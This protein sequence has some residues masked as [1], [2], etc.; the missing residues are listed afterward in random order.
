MS[1]SQ[2]K[3]QPLSMILLIE[4]KNLNFRAVYQFV[5]VVPLTSV[6]KAIK[7]WKQN[8]E[9]AA[10]KGLP[11]GD[12]IW[13]LEGLVLSADFICKAVID[14]IRCSARAVL[15]SVTVK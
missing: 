5:A 14:T 9:S 1:P 10:S 12:N 6:A 8:I 15:H 2:W 11:E 7:V 13:A 3:I 4:G